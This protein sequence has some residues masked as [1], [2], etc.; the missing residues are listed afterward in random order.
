MISKS[1]SDNKTKQTKLS[2][3]LN[4][5]SDNLQTGGKNSAKTQEK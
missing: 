2:K 5:D 3:L 1:P 4:L